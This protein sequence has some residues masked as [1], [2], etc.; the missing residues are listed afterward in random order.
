M[1]SSWKLPFIDYITYHKLKQKKEE[2]LIISSKSRNSTI[3]PK[4][5]NRIIKVYNGSKFNVLKIK[6]EHVG[7]KLG[8]FAITKKRCIF[9]KKMKRK[10]KK[11][12]LKKKKSTIKSKIK[13]K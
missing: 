2:N 12:P 13:K 10:N 3:V 1:R 11:Q 6:E 8:D 4:M 9:K 7:Y 5:L